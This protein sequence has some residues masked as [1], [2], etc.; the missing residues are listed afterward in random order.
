MSRGPDGTEVKAGRRAAKHDPHQGPRDDADDDAPSSSLGS[1]ADEDDEDD[2]GIMAVIRDKIKRDEAQWH[3]GRGGEG[4]GELVPNE[5]ENSRSKLL[6]PTPLRQTTYMTTNTTTTITAGGQV[7]PRRHHQQR[8]GG[9]DRGEGDG[10][11]ADGLGVGLAVVVGKPQTPQGSVGLPPISRPGSRG[12]MSSPGSARGAGGEAP[13]RSR[14]VQSPVP[15]GSFQRD[16]A[17]PSPR[18]RR[19]GR[20]R[21]GRGSTALAG[22]VQALEALLANDAMFR[23][24]APPAPEWEAAVSRAAEEAGSVERFGSALRT[25][26]SSARRR[27]DDLRGSSELLREIEE[28][29][30]ELGARTASFGREL[31]EVAKLNDVA[32]DDGN[33]DGSGDAETSSSE[34]PTTVVPLPAPPA[35][36]RPSNSRGALRGGVG[37]GEEMR[38]G[39]HYG[40]TAQG[41]RAGSPA[42]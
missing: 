21:A 35:G 11:Q 23:A 1:D 27:V 40:E 37:G 16:A 22:E 4:E 8:R 5:K 14:A 42:G 28:M 26:V 38:A 29:T 2:N 34:T 20:A 31:A 41:E 25:R 39:V 33:D 30:A 18:T 6:E 3:S 10:L 36:E 12:A 15:S 32:L 17:A 24:P 19:V 13:G 7:P 9:G